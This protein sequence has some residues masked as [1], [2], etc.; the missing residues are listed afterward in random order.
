VWWLENPRLAIALSGALP[1]LV[2]MYIVD[3]RINF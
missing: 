3:R 1:A 2:A